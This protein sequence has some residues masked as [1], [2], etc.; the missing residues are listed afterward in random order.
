[1]VIKQKD[2]ST[3]EE[4]VSSGDG[5]GSPARLVIAVLVSGFISGLLGATAGGFCAS[6]PF[7]GDGAVLVGIS[8]AVVSAAIGSYF[9][10]MHSTHSVQPSRVISTLQVCP[11]SQ[12]ASGVTTPAPSRR[13]RPAG[14]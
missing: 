14:L 4:A 8:A 1:M 10:A 9:I 2:D 12:G 5:A 3:E 11:V 7:S 6:T 13:Q